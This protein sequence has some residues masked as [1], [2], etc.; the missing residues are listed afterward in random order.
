MTKSEEWL[1]RIEAWRA[2]GKK[3]AE[4]CAG[5]D[6]TAKSLQ[7]W[8][9]HFDGSRSKRPSSSKRVQFARVVARR[10]AAQ[11]NSVTGV[12]VHVG[13]ARVEIAVGADHAIV[14]TVLE[15]LRSSRAGGRS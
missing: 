12:V 13:G 6:Y 14:S 8:A 2:S 5:R 7:W 11:T 4:F 1:K 3:A 9:W 10:G 15:A